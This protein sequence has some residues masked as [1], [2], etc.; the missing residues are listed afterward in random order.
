MLD[1]NQLGDKISREQTPEDTFSPR[2]ASRNQAHPQER[3][4]HGTTTASFPT[5]GINTPVAVGAQPNGNIVAAGTA[6][7]GID[8]ATE[9]ALARFMPNGKLD[10]TFGQGSLVTTEP[11]GVARYLAI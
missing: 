8:Q 6:S 3:D 5:S 2:P 11:A 9:F 4:L 10:T 7:P 1:V